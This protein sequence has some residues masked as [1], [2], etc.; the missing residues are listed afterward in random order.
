MLTLAKDSKGDC[1]KMATQF[2]TL[3]DSNKALTAADKKFQDSPEDRKWFDDQYGEA[4]MNTMTLLVKE[5]GPCKD[6][7]A[8]Q[9]AL[10]SL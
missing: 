4:L 6:N 9:K 7:L 1:A 3:V 5:I 2:Q 10:T 8:V